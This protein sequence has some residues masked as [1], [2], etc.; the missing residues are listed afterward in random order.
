MKALKTIRRWTVKALGLSLLAGAMVLG[1]P[2]LAQGPSPA[3]LPKVTY[4][5]N[6]TF[7]LPVQMD[8]A[9]RAGLREVCLYVKAGSAD[10]VRQET[11]LPSMSHFSYKVPRDGEYW[12]SLVTV[13]K[14]G[15][16]NP[17]DVSQ[18]PP[19]LR[20]LV[21]T[22]APAVDV[23]PW[24][25][26]EGDFCLRCQ[27][28]D[29]NPDPQSLKATY[30]NETGEHIL[31]PV[32]GTTNLFKIA[33]RDVLNQPLRVSASDLCGNVGAREVN[34]KDMVVAAMNTNKTPAPSV[35][36]VST[37]VE[38]PVSVPNL[39][40]DPFKTEAQKPLFPPLPPL[41]EKSPASVNQT[42]TV[43]ATPV[44]TVPMNTVPITMPANTAPINTV[45][46]PAV[47]PGQ[48]LVP[49]PSAQAPALPAIPHVPMFTNDQVSKAGPSVSNPPVSN[50]PVS[51]PPVSNPPA[52]NAPVAPA[53]RGNSAKQILNSSH[54][55]LEY[56]IDTVGPSGVGK[57]E[58]Y[59]T[60]DG[61]LNWQRLQEDA[62]RRSPAEIDLPGEGLFGVRLVVTNGNGF[63]GTPPAR[64]DAPT[65]WIEIDTT[66]PFV[67]LRPIDPA[68]N[69][70]LE[71]RWT[72][73]DK[74]LGTEPV[75]LYY[76]MRSD[77]PW[78]VIARNLKN[79][80]LYKWTFPRDQGSQFFVKV[81]V[82]D[83]A[84]NT[85]RAETPNAIILDMT[86]PRASVVGVTSMAP[87]VTPPSGN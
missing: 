27:V 63:G 19:G 50:P 62:D 67:Q 45:A 57:V 48:T 71:L 18:D 42:S 3:K 30:R 41:P 86:E 84:G 14:A 26:P 15:K 35:N 43:Y 8:E 79:D 66:V 72:A 21:D 53:T 51:N 9:T 28:Q 73:S 40:A 52:G 83:M 68:Q 29:A 20:V 47:N 22:Q 61:G 78:Q 69:G 55:T 59:L 77:T 76:R 33:G 37:N 80:G 36:Q 81:E 85:A 70:V 10:W 32:A 11:G 44:S 46:V 82:A 58:V 75:N 16:M 4:T 5:K 31:E 74:N 12:F 65:C 2:T 24:T 25:S 56:R 54:A 87:R 6:T 64:G 17:A 7:H 34:V 38:A 49:P 39:P 60:G 23:Q 1:S 13:D